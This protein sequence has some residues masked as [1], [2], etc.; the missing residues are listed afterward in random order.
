MKVAIN[1]L[2]HVTGGGITYL[3][4]ILPR[5]SDDG[6]EYVVLVPQGRDKII[7]PAARNISFVEVASPIDVLLVRLLYEQFV[8]PI[9]LWY[10]DIDVLFSPADLTPLLAPCPAVLAIRNPNPYHQVHELDRT[11]Y[12][13]FKFRVQRYLTRISA[14][15]ADRVFFV[16]NYSKDMSN[17]YLN[18]NE[19][20]LDVIY[21]GID[22][23]LFKN[24]L[25]DD[26]DAVSA[27][28]K[29][30]PYLLCVSTI[31]EHKNYEALLRGYARLPSQIRVKFPLVVAGRN[32]APVYFERLQ[33]L[34]ISEG[35]E[36]DVVFLG[37]VDYRDIPSLYAGAAA[38]VLPSKLETFGHTLVEA[39]ASG[40][41]IA[42]A[43]AT[44][45]PEI[46]D[47][48]A[49]L[50]DPDDPDDVAEALKAVLTDDAFQD[51]LIQRGAERVQDFSW[52]RTVSQTKVLLCEAAKGGR[53]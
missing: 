16:S 52:D 24:Q 37:E 46:T 14:W 17:K 50:F 22:Q 26:S 35:I 5:L 44:C 1:T 47:G 48:A 38:Y 31:N 32:S 49:R 25:P 51:R 43:D 4:N 15:K 34:M 30:A 3:S 18:I 40:C 41:P 39:M 7:E 53:N 42:A 33:K 21:H 20:K 12:R 10:W 19:R 8:F 28:E 27:V 2:S 9:L 36:N 13:R 11:L 6:N 23:E 29:S 45:I